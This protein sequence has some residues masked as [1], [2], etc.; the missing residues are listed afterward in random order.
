MTS[1]KMIN[2]RLLIGAFLIYSLVIISNTQAQTANYLPVNAQQ[3]TEKKHSNVAVATAHPAATAAGL[4]ILKQGGNAFDAAVAITAVLAVVEPYSSGLG[5]GGFWLLHKNDGTEIMID[6]R[7]KAPLKAHKDMYLDDLGFVIPNA[8]INGPLAAGIPGV[9]AAIDHISKKYGTMALTKT[10]QPAIKAAQEG[11][12]VD[13]IFISLARFRKQALLDS[14]D[15]KKIFLNNNAVPKE[16]YVIKQPDLANTLQLMA[17]QGRDGFYQGEVAQKML[18][19]VQ[20][21]GGI[22]TQKDFNQ[23]QIVERNP[24]VGH[25]NDMEIVSVGPPSSGGTTLISILNMLEQFKIEGLHASERKHYIIEAMRRAYRDRAEYLGD[26]DYVDVP[27]KKLIHPYYSKGLATTILKE[28]ATPSESLRPVLPL[29]E[30]L[31]TTHFSVVDNKGNYVSA[32]LSVNYPFGSGFVAEGTGILLNDEMDD[33]V[34]KAGEPNVYG[35]VGADAN[36]I[37]PGKRM[38]SSM[39]PS[40]LKKGNKVAIIGT[41]GGSRIITMVLLGA[42]GFYED[43]NAT[44]IVSIPRFH[45]QYLP[46]HVQYEAKAFNRDDELNLQ[47]KGH[48]IQRQSGEYG[49]MQLIIW[50]KDSNKMDAAS[51]P[52][53]NG[54]AKSISLSN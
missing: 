11:F 26:S 47:W 12:K 22:W 48:K 14:K 18:Q 32:T 8:S 34:S 53:G 45:H 54:D 31:H 19:S 23:Y 15:A 17:T 43:K 2:K 13:K 3:Q 1:L 37:A 21:N 35:L 40:F 6:G 27:V 52:R 39:S 30:G 7:E 46:D 20:A 10:L 49:N 24:L 29:K 28:K 16:G 4:A 44:E 25:Y 36:S 50:D 33:F 51:D 9:P 38:L 5:G 41:P 42:L